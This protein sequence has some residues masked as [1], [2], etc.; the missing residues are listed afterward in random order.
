MQ[1]FNPFQAPEK[2]INIHGEAFFTLIFRLTGIKMVLTCCP[3]MDLT[4]QAQECRR[5]GPGWT[6]ECRRLD[7]LRRG[8]L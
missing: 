3:G 1:F 4:P 5:I 6:T 7:V 8:G 2:V